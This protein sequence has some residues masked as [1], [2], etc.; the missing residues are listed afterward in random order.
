MTRLDGE[1]YPAGTV[2]HRT[3]SGLWRRVATT[4]ALLALIAALVSCSSSSATPGP[5]STGPSPSGSGT[6]VS[7]LPPGCQ[8]IDLRAPDGS[9]VD[10]EGE[11]IDVSRQDAAQM[12]WWIRTAGDCFY[13]V[14]FIP[15]QVDYSDSFS[16]QSY[17][18]VIGPDFTIDG[19]FIHLGGHNDAET[20][21]EYVPATLLIEF[22]DDGTIAI[23]EDREPNAPGPRCPRP[24]V[25][26]APLELR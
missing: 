25:C 5:S 10:L 9:P 18:G 21:A 2:I 11:W 24:E 20:I 16:V 7:G 1:P 17:S 15:Q 3:G 13:G 19:A 26:A 22:E 23:R 8:T 12:I 4:S 6:A 14:G